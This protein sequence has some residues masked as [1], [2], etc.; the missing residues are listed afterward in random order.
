MVQ[1]T[2]SAYELAR[3]NFELQ[4]PEHFNFVRDVVERWAEDTQKRAL[5]WVDERGKRQ[6]LTFRQ[7]AE[8]SAKL[9][10]GLRQLGVKKGDRV[11]VVIPPNIGSI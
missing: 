3:Q 4:V 6:D 10:G 2:A 7:I 8:R 5:L 11:L 1:S 9:A